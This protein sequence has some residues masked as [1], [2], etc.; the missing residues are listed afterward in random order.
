MHGLPAHAHPVNIFKATTTWLYARARERALSKHFTHWGHSPGKTFNSVKNVL[1]LNNVL[2]AVI[3]A[4]TTGIASAAPVTEQTA[5]TI[6]ISC[7]T[8][9]TEFALCNDGVKRW[10]HERNS[11]QHS[12]PVNVLVDAAP[13][14]HS[15]RFNYY[16]RELDKQKSGSIDIFQIDVVWVASL[17]DNFIDLEP[18][19]PSKQ[20]DQDIIGNNTIERL[21]NNEIKRDV[22]VAIPWFADK[23]LLY[24]RAD[25]LEKYGYGQSGPQTWDELTKVAEHIQNAERECCNPQIIGFV[26]EGANDEGL[27][28]NA[29]EWIKSFGGNILTRDHKIRIVDDNGREASGIDATEKAIGMA[30]SWINGPDHT[31]SSKE[32]L[33]YGEDKALNTFLSRNAVFMR[34][35]PYAWAAIRGDRDAEFETMVRVRPLPTHPENEKRVSFGTMGGWELAVSKWSKNRELAVELA[36]YLS[37]KEEQKQRAIDGGYIPTISEVREQVDTIKKTELHSS[38]D[39]RMFE[40][41]E[42]V[43]RPSREGEYEEFSRCFR[44]AVHKAL[45]ANGSATDVL[46]LQ[47]RS[48]KECVQE[49]ASAH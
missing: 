43:I 39:N 27:T 30:R 37:G 6:T 32:V 20:Y 49:P 47:H 40:Y 44:E 33:G 7:G 34:H 8:V 48:V 18:F 26:W 16:K 36:I 1:M 28:C 17:A 31:I 35:W 5:R 11:N 9:G 21:E 46:K 3:T 25:L 23:G 19:I 4:L 10:Q 14:E 13:I 22:I 12:Q 42:L 45:S 38:G 29:L 41:I 24:E 2:S 15:E